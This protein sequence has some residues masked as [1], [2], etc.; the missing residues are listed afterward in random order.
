MRLPDASDCFSVVHRTDVV[1]A[2]PEKYRNTTYVLAARL[3]VN[4]MSL[5]DTIFVRTLILS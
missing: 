3:A 5:N 1:A 4:L 2:Y